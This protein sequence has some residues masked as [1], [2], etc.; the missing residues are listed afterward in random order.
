MTSIEI[1]LGL[2]KFSYEYLI[3][4]SRDGTQQLELNLRIVRK[5]A[6]G[7]SPPPLSETMSI[8]SGGAFPVPHRFSQERLHNPRS[9]PIKVFYCFSIRHQGDSVEAMFPSGIIGNGS[10]ARLLYR[11]PDSAGRRGEPR[12]SNRMYLS[13]LRAGRDFSHCDQTPCSW[14]QGVC[15]ALGSARP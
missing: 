6:R 5:S 12:G 7:G 13:A 15:H 9:L 10:Q 8:R 3:H 14:I 2:S 1:F 4:I 11:F